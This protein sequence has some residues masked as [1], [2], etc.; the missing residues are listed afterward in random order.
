MK[1]TRVASAESVPSYLK[2]YQYTFRR[3]YFVKI[4]NFDSLH[5]RALSLGSI[6]FPLRI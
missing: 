5:S 2:V 1:M 3:S 4:F 6:F